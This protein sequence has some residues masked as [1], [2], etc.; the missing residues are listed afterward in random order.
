MYTQSIA[1]PK[2]DLVHAHA[3][4]F[5]EISAHEPTFF[6]AADGMVTLKSQ[7]TIYCFFYAYT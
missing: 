1:R 4:R 7:S 5:L 2:C 3:I 6:V